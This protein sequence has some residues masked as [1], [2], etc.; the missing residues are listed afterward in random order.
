MSKLISITSVD[1]ETR[2]RTGILHLS[3]GDV[4]TPVFMPVGTNGTVKAIKHDTLEAMGY[5][6][7]LGNTYH[8]YLRPGTDIIEAAGGLHDF[9]GWKGNILT[10]SGG[11]QVFS[12]AQFRKIRDDGVKFRSHIDGSYHVFTPENVVDYQVQLGS[13]IQMPLDVCT[14]PGIKEKEALGAL[15]TTTRWAK[16]ALK[17][18]QEHQDHYKGQLFGIIQGNFFHDLRK[19]SLDELV[20][21]DLPGYAIGGL[22]VGEDPTIFR[23]FLHETAAGMPFDKP[24]YVMGI[25]TPDF[26]LEAVDAGID[27]FDCVF[28]TRVARNS[29]CFTDQGMLSLKKE[30]Y[31]EDFLPIDPECGCSVCRTYSRS[32]LRHLFKASEILGPMLVTEHNLYYL[33]RFME[34]IRKAI[35]QGQFSRF[36]KDFMRSFG[37][38]G[39]KQS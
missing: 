34:R 2:A 29:T 22:S 28:P 10:D 24:R 18:W 30:D 39:L 9:T 1:T 3:R 35:R 38:E 36:K 8:L 4:E 21:L 17:R 13:D 27:M 5:N 31:K 16:Q 25:G 33:A 26:M 32:Y 15:I 23:E 11:F 6:L 12:L 19:R 14:P 7:I 20:E 37:R